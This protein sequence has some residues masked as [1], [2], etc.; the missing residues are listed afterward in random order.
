MIVSGLQDLVAPCPRIVHC[1]WIMLIIAMYLM[2][3]LLFSHGLFNFSGRGF[4]TLPSGA[5]RLGREL[6]FQFGPSAR[7][8][9]AGFDSRGGFGN[10]SARIVS[11]NVC[12]VP[13]W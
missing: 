5:W 11:R 8:V 3:A 6:G 2:S 9:G 1:R 4:L 13:I 7:A 12:L 10:G